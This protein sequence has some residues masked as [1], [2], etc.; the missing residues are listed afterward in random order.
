MGKRDNYYLSKMKEDCNNKK[1]M[2][3][4]DSKFYKKS[5]LSRFKKF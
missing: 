4:L 3:I 2:F 5:I 1:C